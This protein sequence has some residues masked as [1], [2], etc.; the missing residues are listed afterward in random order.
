[1]EIYWKDRKDD[2]VGVAIPTAY[3]TL[4]EFYNKIQTLVERERNGI[5]W[6]DQKDDLDGVTIPTPY[7]QQ[8]SRFETNRH[9]AVPSVLKESKY[10]HIFF[11]FFPFVR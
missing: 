8:F 9:N 7:L 3:T 6:K 4:T 5:Y 10:V 11:S 1:M 2:M